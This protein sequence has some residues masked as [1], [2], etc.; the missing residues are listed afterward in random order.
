MIDIINEDEIIRLLNQTAPSEVNKAARK[1]LHKASN[2]LLR[3]VRQALKKTGLKNID[4]INIKKGFKDS[5][6]QGIRKSKIKTKDNELTQI[7][8]ADSN[9][10]KGSGSFRLM[11]IENT[12]NEERFRRKYKN[13]PKRGRTGIFNAKPFYNP[14]IKE[15][16]SNIYKIIETE[17]IK[18]IQ[19]LNT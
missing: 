15:N 7:V 13:T 9:Y 3:K 10:K 5:L 17:I 19:K 16:E 11:I 1:G 14:T 2:Y 6:L 18:T 4:R 12:K 8:R